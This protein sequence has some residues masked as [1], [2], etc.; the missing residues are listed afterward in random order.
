[1]IEIVDKN[2][3]G[4]LAYVEIAGAV[5]K[6]KG[7]GRDDLT[8]KAIQTLVLRPFFCRARCGE[9]VM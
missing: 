4:K 5:R 1:M 2:K 6:L 8:D 3:D 9:A 7:N